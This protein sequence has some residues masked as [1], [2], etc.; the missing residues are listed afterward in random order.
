MLI[1]LSPAKNMNFDPVAG[2]PAATKPAFLKEA[3]EVADAARALT[4]A[5]LK[6]MMSISDKLA[7][8]NHDRFQ[9]FRGDGKS[10][11]QKPAAL[12]FNGDVYIGLDAKTMKPA[13]FA[14]AQDHVRILSG[15]Y[16]LLRPLDAIEP[17]RLVMGSSLKNP[18]GKDLYAFW[19]DAIA[20]EINKTLKG[21]KH[22]VVVN[23]ASNEYFSAVDRNALEADVIT[24]TFKDEKDGKLRALQFFAKRARGSMTRWIIDNR[25]EEPEA[26]KKS[27][28]DGYKFR[29]AESTAT[30]WLFARKQPPLK[31]KV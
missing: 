19:G 17:Y 28:A 4:P 8:L 29:A 7:E 2:A 10:N 12:A 11:A 5:K 18:R 1:L 25:I 26:I 15:L 20:K 24:P 14:F 6:K 31:G 27:N 23:L 16:G 3:R 13:D 22:P 30:E 21:R 9:A